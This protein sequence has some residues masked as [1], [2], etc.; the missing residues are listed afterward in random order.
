MYLL[1][2][3]RRTSRYL[4]S[5]TTRSSSTGYVG[6]SRR[7]LG[8]LGGSILAGTT[9]PMFAANETIIVQE[10]K[11]VAQKQVIKV[12]IS[13]KSEQ[14]G[15][16]IGS[17]LEWLHET[18]LVLW[19]C[20]TLCFYFLAPAATLP[21]VLL[22]K[23]EDL[24]K[25]WWDMLR[26]SICASG[27]S[28]IKLSQWAAMRTD[29]FHRRICT[30]LAKLQS[31]AH[32][33]SWLET[34]R[35]L[36]SVLGENWN[37]TLQITASDLVGSGCVAQV[38][39]GFLSVQ[40]PSSLHIH[41]PQSSTDKKSVSIERTEVAVKIIHPGV[42]EALQLDLSLMRSAARTVEWL[43]DLLLSSL[44]D[45]A[46]QKKTSTTTCGAY[47]VT[48]KV[49]KESSQQ[50]SNSSKSSRN[51]SADNEGGASPSTALPPLRCVSLVDTVDQ[52]A[53]FMEAQL[54]MTHEAAALERLRYVLS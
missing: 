14:V 21:V 4:L 23:H 27:P 48:G 29:L 46:H 51:I 17:Y 7:Y 16:L 39:R 38:Y 47:N 24:E 15:S 5:A 12:A 20:G 44:S 6:P 32:V 2:K 8:I 9:L 19:R 25:F 35:V 34:D 42:R 45:V 43:G 36:R 18:L 40:P 53:A 49:S 37:Q 50:S 3:A 52:F 13:Q 41:T 26:V 11:A 10:E 54:D 28:F 31:G 33:H 30:E 1:W 22:S